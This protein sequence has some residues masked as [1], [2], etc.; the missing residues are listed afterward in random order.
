MNRRNFIKS[1]LASGVLGSSPL[2]AQAANELFRPGAAQ[3]VTIIA[4]SGLPHADE[5]VARLERVFA[6]A[7]IDYVRTSSSASE[8]NEFPYLTFLFDRIPGHRVIG[9]MDDA[10]AMVFQELAAARGAACVINT[11][12]RFSGQEVRHCC[13]SAG[14]EGNIVWSDA[15]PA[16]AERISRLYAGTLGGQELAAGRGARIVGADLA[17]SADSAAASLVSFMIN[18]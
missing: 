4:Q 18:T 9:V 7:G 14:L 11:H 5:L 2:A 16:H 1:L 3:P 13:T 15:L 12:H 10:A 17:G 6:A 8:L